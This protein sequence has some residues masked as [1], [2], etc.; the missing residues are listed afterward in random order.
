MSKLMIMASIGPAL[1]LGFTSSSPLSAQPF[2]PWPA[3]LRNTIQ[4]VADV[5]WRILKAA[6]NACPATAVGHGIIFDSL[7][8]YLKRDHATV[9]QH[10]GMSDL[11]QVSAVAKQ[12]PADL[13]GIKV[14]DE[15]VA[16]NGRAS[17]AGFKSGNDENDT[18]ALRVSR[19]L[20][21]LPLD[22]T[23]QMNFRREGEPI[24]IELT[25]ERLCASRIYVTTENLINAYTDGANIAIPARMVEFTRT[26]DELAILAGHE[27][28]HIIARDADGSKG[29][30]RRRAE[31]RA[32]LTGA[33]LATCAGYD[34]KSAAHF[35][36]RLE[37]RKP[38]RFLFRKMQSPGK[39]RTKNVL[40]RR[41]PA[42]C[43]ISTAA[44]MPE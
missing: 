2:E 6:G 11:P 32:D 33:D 38:L 24:S 13:A 23:I 7:D 4:R 10:F 40:D 29:S 17:D 44:S 26:D 39:V 28:G 22:Q 41:P 9:V 30:E 3:R 12:S 5:E 27:L 18:L 36:K 34:T 20:A 21:H 1:M 16:I 15:L 35:W 25:P 14:G 37:Q 43:P 19:A 42:H 31:D 8:A